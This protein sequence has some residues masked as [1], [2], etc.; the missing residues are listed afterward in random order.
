MAGERRT[1][2]QSCSDVRW[3]EVSN[4]EDIARSNDLKWMTTEMSGGP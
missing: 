1:N 3:P 4:D 2:C